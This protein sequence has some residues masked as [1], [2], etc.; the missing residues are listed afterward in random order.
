MFSRGTPQVYAIASEAGIELGFGVAIHES[1]YYNAEIKR[2]NRA[3]VPVL[4]NKL[5]NPNSELIQNSEA[6]LNSEQGWL[7]GLKTR[8]GP[9]EVFSVSRK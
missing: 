3:I 2:R 4:Y 8:Q 7:Y 1:D 9:L 6:Q 5:P